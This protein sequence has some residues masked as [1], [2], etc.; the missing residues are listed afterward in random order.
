M[1]HCSG[2]L[3]S[4]NRECLDRAAHQVEVGSR[5]GMSDPHAAV[6]SFAQITAVEASQTSQT[7]LRHNAAREVT[8]VSV[9]TQQTYHLKSIFHQA[10]LIRWTAAKLNLVF[11]NLRC[12]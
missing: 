4:A 7:N 1:Q 10:R 3:L 11:A 6:G 5:T 12:S 8:T 2:K 9:T